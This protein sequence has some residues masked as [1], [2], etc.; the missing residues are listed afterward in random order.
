MTPRVSGRRG[1]VKP[2]LF[3]PMCLF[4][5]MS[6]VSFVTVS[7]LTVGLLFVILGQSWYIM[8]KVGRI[9]G[10]LSELGKRLGR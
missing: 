3:L 6:A 5:S 1:G 8:Y 7:D 9:E 4:F 2:L 10:R